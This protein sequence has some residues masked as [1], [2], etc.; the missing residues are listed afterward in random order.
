MADFDG[1]MIDVPTNRPSVNPNP[2]DD[3]NA[4]VDE[5]DWLHILMQMSP[6]ISAVV[7]TFSYGA[8]FGPAIYTWTSELFPSN[9]KGI[10]SSVALARYFNL[11]KQ[12]LSN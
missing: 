1:N 4:K 6:P 12:M 5:V 11:L 2:A 3:V 10:G 8:G 7:Y 9:L